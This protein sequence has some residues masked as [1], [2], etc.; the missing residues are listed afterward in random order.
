[1]T[2]NLQAQEP[3]IP[4]D[5]IELLGEFDAED[6]DSIKEAVTQVGQAKTTSAEV[7]K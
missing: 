4:L 7:R 3:S 6:T 1:M 2:A 5:L